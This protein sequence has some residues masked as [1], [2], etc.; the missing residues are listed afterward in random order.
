MSNSV[1]ASIR[2]APNSQKTLPTPT[3]Q[4]FLRD[5]A[6]GILLPHPHISSPRLWIS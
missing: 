6:G 3:I 1:K 5:L 4:V 2:K